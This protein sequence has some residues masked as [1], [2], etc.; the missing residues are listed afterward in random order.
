MDRIDPMFIKRKNNIYFI[1]YINQPHRIW[2]PINF[3]IP[4]YG[5]DYVKSKLGIT[6][7]IKQ[8]DLRIEFY[9]NIR[10]SEDDIKSDMLEQHFLDYGR[11]EYPFYLNDKTEDSVTVFIEKGLD[12]LKPNPKTGV[13]EHAHGYP[14]GIIYKDDSPDEIALKLYYDDDGDFGE[15]MHKMLKKLMNW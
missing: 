6:D 7:P 10:L 2:Y 1:S 13:W 11:F 15:V 8:R 3:K 14:W 4:R 12:T 5:D 9:D